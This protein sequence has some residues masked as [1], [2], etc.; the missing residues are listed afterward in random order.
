MRAAYLAGTLLVE[1]FPDESGK[2]NI[3]MAPSGLGRTHP[4]YNICNGGLGWVVDVE[5][6]AAGLTDLT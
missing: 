2:H 3:G 1:K 6:P 4:F 5:E